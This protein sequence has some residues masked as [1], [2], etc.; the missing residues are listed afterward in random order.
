MVECE[1]P[2]K[3]GRWGNFYSR[4]C[5]V[6]SPPD[7]GIRWFSE[8]TLYR[9][10][11][12]LPTEGGAL[13]DN[14][15]GTAD[16]LGKAC[17]T[18]GSSRQDSSSFIVGPSASP[19]QS[20]GVEDNGAGY[21]IGSV[22][23]SSLG[24]D[25][26]AFSN[27]ETRNDTFVLENKASPKSEVI[28]SFCNEN[29]HD[30][31]FN[32][33]I[34]NGVTPSNLN[35]SVMLEDIAVG[36]DDGDRKIAEGTVAC[37]LLEV[38]ETG[39]LYS[40]DVFWSAQDCGVSKDQSSYLREKEETSHSIADDIWGQVCGS[41]LV[42]MPST[43]QCMN[44]ERSIGKEDVDQAQAIQLKRNPEET[45]DRSNDSITG[46]NAYA[47]NRESSPLLKEGRGCIDKGFQ[48]KSTVDL[49]EF[50]PQNCQSDAHELVDH[51]NRAHRTGP[52][53]RSRR[54]CL[55]TSIA[56][57]VLKKRQ[58]RLSTS[59]SLKGTISRKTNFMDKNFKKKVVKGLLEDYLKVWMDKNMQAGALESEHCLPFLVHAPRRVECYQCKALVSSGKE[60]LCTVLNCRRAFHLV[61][62]KNLQGRSWS[63]KGEFKCPQHVCMA[64]GSRVGLWRCVRCP[65]AV[66]KACSPWPEAMTLL[67]DTPG[68]AVCWRHHEDWRLDHKSW[69]IFC[70][71]AVRG[72]DT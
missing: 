52:I 30:M 29:K 21:D 65:V 57:S 19:N 28:A 31:G 25:P 22:K 12:C 64:C 44:E 37:K 42:I 8:H 60:V 71:A 16:I 48:L 3:R 70:H 1:V 39:M 24:S 61:C 34:T 47:R 72:T 11:F 41:Q 50:S 38:P 27:V 14:R 53:L 4:K 45:Q 18:A 46:K 36:L 68:P 5:G 55:E 2:I 17:L 33:G 59:S 35:K 62:A 26:D 32:D 10:R 40:E 67:R 63:R 23:N 49:D 20:S 7:E 56:T 58:R 6:R 69:W 13:G 66:H 54:I 43:N 15:N 9:H 51:H